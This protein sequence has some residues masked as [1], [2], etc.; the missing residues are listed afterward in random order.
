MELGASE[1]YNGVAKV[2]NE[3]P[4]LHVLDIYCPWGIPRLVEASGDYMSY[5]HCITEWGPEV[6]VP[7]A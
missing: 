6:E 1:E 3:A 7:D 2:V 4:F 5:L